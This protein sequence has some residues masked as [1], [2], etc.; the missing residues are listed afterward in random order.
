MKFADGWPPSFKGL[1]CSRRV[2]TSIQDFFMFTYFFLLILLTV[3]WLS[4]SFADVVRNEDIC[5]PHNGRRLYVELGEQGILYAANVSLVKNSPRQDTSRAYTANSSH[6]QC[7]LEL[8]TCPSCVITLTFKSI[9]LLHHCGDGSMTIDS[10]CRCDYVWISEPPYEDVSGTPFCGHY[11]PISY[12]SNTRTLSIALL[13][14]QSHKHAFALE[15][16]AERNRLILKGSNSLTEM[17]KS[18]NNSGGGGILTS[19]FFPSRYPRDLGM[20]YI[21]TCPTEAPSCRVRVL[22]SDFQ[23]AAVSIMEFYDWNGQRLDVSSG[24]RFR[25]PIIVSTGPSLLIRFYANGGTGL[26]YKAFYSFVPVHLYDKHSHPITDCGGY[27][28]NLGGTITMMDMVGEGVKTYDCVWLIRPPKSFLHM[29]T[30][31][32]L[33]VITF[34]EMAGNTELIIKQGPTS[35]LMPLEVLRH[36]VSQLQPPRLREQ[37]APVTSGFHVSLRGSFGPNSRLAIAYAA[38]SYMDVV[39]GLILDCFTGSDFL[40]Q[41]HRCISSQ[42]NCD[43][44]DHCGDNSDE[45]STCLHDWD[46]GLSDRKWQQSKANYYFPKIDRYPDLKTATLVFV[47]SSLGLIVL[48]SALIILLYR[49]GA[50]ARQQ[51]E[52]QSRLRTISELLD[53]ARIDEIS[54]SDDP[55]VYEAPPNYDEVIKLGMEDE[56]TTATTTAAASMSC[57]NGSNTRRK[58]Q[59]S[60]RDSR[61][62]RSIPSSQCSCEHEQQQLTLN[63]YEDGARANR[64]GPMT[65]IMPNPMEKPS[66][67][68]SPPPPYVTPPG[69]LQRNFSID[70]AE[71]LPGPSGTSSVP[72]I[73]RCDT[74]NTNSSDTTSTSPVRVHLCRGDCRDAQTRR[75]WLRNSGSFSRSLPTS[76]AASNSPSNADRHVSSTTSVDAPP[77]PVENSALGAYLRA[78]AASSS[79]SFVTPRLLVP[80]QAS[81]SCPAQSARSSAASTSTSSECASGCAS[82]V[83][84]IEAESLES[85]EQ[86]QEAVAVELREEA[87]PEEEDEDDPERAE[88]RPIV[89]CSC[90]GACGCASSGSALLL[91]NPEDSSSESRALV[92]RRNSIDDSPCAKSRIIRLLAGSRSSNNSRSS[93]IA[94]TSLDSVPG[95]IST[96]CSTPCGTFGRS[97]HQTRSKG[98]IPRKLSICSR[99]SSG[100]KV[101][102]ISTYGSFERLPDDFDIVSETTSILGPGTLANTPKATPNRFMEQI[103]AGTRHYSTYDLDS[104][105]ESIRVLDSF[106]AQRGASS[107]GRADE[108]SGA[109]KKR[110]WPMAVML[111]GTPKHRKSSGSEDGSS[112][113][114]SILS[115]RDSR[116]GTTRIRVW[117]STDDNLAK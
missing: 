44:F 41:N 27:V 11:A 116:D 105:Y 46:V 78:V 109:R 25:P 26:G 24:A 88:R 19:P 23:L 36:P 58:K 33:K 18:M 66:V 99:D 110:S 84:P 67:P 12:R 86:R 52:L 45:P 2:C 16:T 31:M 38:F 3:A 83:V 80:S 39:M 96:N 54:V 101:T 82:V 70:T 43:G 85:E 10:P 73:A 5:G 7:S 92:I 29:K 71:P 111:F 21:I 48:I 64:S 35:A 42:L 4:A 14:S 32:Y 15:Y 115:R 57:S 81:A 61:R 69:T 55:P 47:A 102:N 40:C 107:V 108:K 87:E 62:S 89:A 60:T 91:N 72:P 37:L 93:A 17:S 56:T 9:N 95:S 6:D 77:P 59:R 13:Y 51:R 53:G 98:C 103:A 79:S 74:I 106:L 34:A 49:V 90:E 30:H 114:S 63:I 113:S 112:R 50:R 94:A 22:F 20:E 75:S 76:R 104:L 28:E 68:E 117:R 97:C 65:A 1:V 8:V 100:T